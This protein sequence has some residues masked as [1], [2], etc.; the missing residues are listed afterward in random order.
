[1]QLVWRMRYY[2]AV[3]PAIPHASVGRSRVT[4][5][6]AGHLLR[7]AHD[8]HVLS[9]PPA[10]VLSQDQTLQE[11]VRLALRTRSAS[12][13]LASRLSGA[14]ESQKIVG[15]TLPSTPTGVLD[16]RVR[17]ARLLI[18]T[19]VVKQLHHMHPSRSSG[20]PT[21]R[22][23]NLVPHSAAALKSRSG[24]R[25]SQVFWCHTR[26]ATSSPQ[27]ASSSTS[28]ARSSGQFPPASTAAYPIAIPHRT[29]DGHHRRSLRSS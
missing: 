7:G 4:H 14:S 10:F 26:V 13:P 18:S 19:S 17:P 5:P 20:R 3:G 24:F 9:T 23:Q 11:K 22:R 21:G 6:F 28:G 29:G 1:M 2:P 12:P 8:L 16:Q 25:A 15:Q 27:I